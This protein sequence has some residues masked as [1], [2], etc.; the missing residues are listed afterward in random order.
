M[1]VL[2]LTTLTGVTLRLVASLPGREID[3]T[4]NLA[5]MIALAF[6]WWLVADVIGAGIKFAL[7]VIVVASILWLVA[8][9][10]GW[11]PAQLWTDNVPRPETTAYAWLA[12]WLHQ[13]NA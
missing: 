10:M 7:Q 3:V 1:V 5:E 12:N 2:S 6:S 8:A 4:L 9:Y 13:H 11:L